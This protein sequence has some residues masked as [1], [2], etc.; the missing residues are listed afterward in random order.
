[1]EISEQNHII[2][3]CMQA[4]SFY[5]SELNCCKTKTVYL[6]TSHLIHIKL[7]RVMIIIG[8]RAYPTSKFSG[9]FF[10]VEMP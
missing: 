2:W 8:V 9:I 7:D 10:C 6:F 4:F 3:L 1:M 5:P